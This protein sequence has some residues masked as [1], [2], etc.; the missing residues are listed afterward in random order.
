[1]LGEDFSGT[2][3][4]SREWV[5]EIK[6]GRAIAVDLDPEPLERARA[7]GVKAVQGDVRRATNAQRHAADVVFVGNFSIGEIHGRK[8]LVRYLRHARARLKRGGAF[9]CDTYGGS[10]AFSTGA[11][12]R[13]H[14]GPGE[15]QTRYTWEQREA[16]PLTGEVVNA[17]HF[18]VVRAGTV[19]LELT[20]AF[21]YRWR[22]W[23]VPELRDAMVEAGFAR[24]EVY[25]KVPDAVDQDGRAYVR[26]AEELGESFIVCVAARTQ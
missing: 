10:S 4:L 8:D 14:P 3:A 13:V 6:G 19:E 21:V 26:P 25:D 9:V 2:A 15:F 5:R 11:V 22:L 12:V 18:R 23:S 17:L 1:M 7:R 24:T 16:N 20:D